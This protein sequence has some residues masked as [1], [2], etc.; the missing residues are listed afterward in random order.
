MPKCKD[1]RNQVEGVV[2]VSVF[3]PFQHAPDRAQPRLPALLALSA[4]TSRHGYCDHCDS[5][6]DTVTKPH[7][8]A[9]ACR[10]ILPLYLGPG[11][12]GSKSH[13]LGLSDRLSN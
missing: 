1:V 2:D 10:L 5:D 8:R 3:Y 4:V 6:A 12:S 11:G 13:F 7:A 9:D